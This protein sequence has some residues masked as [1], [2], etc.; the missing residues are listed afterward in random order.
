MAHGLSCSAAY[1]SFPDQGPNTCPPHW[2]A[3]CQ[4]LRHQGSPPTVSLLKQSPRLGSQSHQNYKA[5]GACCHPG[6]CPPG[7]A[8]GTRHL[9]GEEE[10]AGACAAC[11]AGGLPQR[12]R[13]AGL[14]PSAPGTPTPQHCA[15]AER[16][17]ELQRTDHSPHSSAAR[18]FPYPQHLNL[19]VFIREERFQM[20]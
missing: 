3:D 5:E 18:P 6:P 16:K 20:H 17:H 13:C 1:G 19:P 8:G 9:P 14:L 2:Q 12:P 4:Q 11:Q 10:A 7:R 15:K